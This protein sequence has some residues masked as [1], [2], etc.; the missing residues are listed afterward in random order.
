MEPNDFC[1]IF[2]SHLMV[3][4]HHRVVVDD[5]NRNIPLAN[6]DGLDFGRI[7]KYHDV[8]LNNDTFI[9]HFDY[10][11]CLCNVRPFETR[12]IILG[13]R[14]AITIHHVDDSEIEDDEI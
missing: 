4:E 1:E 10:L 3:P 11:P 6:G 5:W 7:E 9:F 13:F 8:L 12:V 2:C 14:M